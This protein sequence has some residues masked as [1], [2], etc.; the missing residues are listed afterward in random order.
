M[1]LLNETVHVKCQQ[2][3]FAKKLQQ[4]VNFTTPNLAYI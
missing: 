2:C 4:A 1:Y 3:S